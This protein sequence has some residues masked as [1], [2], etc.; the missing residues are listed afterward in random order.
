ML[1]EIAAIPGVDGVILT[2]DDFSDRHRAVR[3]SHPAADGQSREDLGRSVSG[4]QTRA[5]EAFPACAAV[6]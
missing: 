3:P 2:F 4:R 1:G 6:T 5:F